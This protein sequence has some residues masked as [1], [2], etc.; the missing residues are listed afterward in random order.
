MNFVLKLIFT[1]KKLYGSNILKYSYTFG[2]IAAMGK[3]DRSLN[4]SFNIFYLEKLF[5]IFFKYK[6]SQKKQAEKC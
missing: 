5:P 2:I 4:D 1:N 6:F 3:K